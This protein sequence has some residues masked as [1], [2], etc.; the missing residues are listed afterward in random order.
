MNILKQLSSLQVSVL[1]FSVRN[2][3]KKTISPHDLIAPEGLLRI[4]VTELV[5]RF[6]TGDIQRID[7][8]LD[9]LREL[10][11]IGG[12]IGM[13]GG[14]NLGDDTANLTPT[15]LA[16]HM[17]VRAQGSRLSPKEY[18]GLCPPE[19]NESTDGGE[20]SVGLSQ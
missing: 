13:G 15:P 18:W 12:P 2:S 16:L 8:E 11:L 6:G 14:I 3:G 10:G 17:Y 19:E 5:I 7:R 4:P 9:H 1:R 20:H